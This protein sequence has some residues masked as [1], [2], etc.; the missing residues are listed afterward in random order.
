MKKIILYIALLISFINLQA[1]SQSDYNLAF[2]YYN[3]QDFEKA[4]VLFEKIFKQ[5]GSKSYFTYYMS[6]LLELKDFENAEKVVKKQLKK[7][8]NDNFYT[9][10]LGYV[11]KKQNFL[12]Q[13]EEQFSKAID[14]LSTEQYAA[15]ELANIFIQRRDYPLAEK[16]YLKAREKGASYSYYYELASV[17]SFDRN[18]EKMIN[19]YTNLLI[20]DETQIGNIQN[21]LQ[22]Y[23]SNDIDGSF[24]EILR[25]TTLKKL[26]QKPDE[27]ILNELLIWLFIQKNNFSAAF[28]QEVAIDKRFDLAGQRILNLGDLAFSNDDFEAANKSFNYIV[29]LH[30]KSFFYAQAKIK[31][32]KVK[33][34]ILTNNKQTLKTE[35]ENLEKEYLATLNDLGQTARTIPLMIELAHIQAFYLEKMQQGID[36]LDYASGLPDVKTDVQAQCFLEMADIYMLMGEVWEATLIYAKV[37]KDNEQNPIGHEAKFKKAQLAFYIGDFRWAEAQLDALKAATSKLIANDAFQLSQL[38]KDNLANDTVTDALKIFARA[39]LLEVQDKN[40]L[41]LI[42]LDTL[43]NQYTANSVIDEAWL[44]KADIM[45][46][47]K[48]YK[49]EALFLQKIVDDF[50]F[51]IL[52]D[53]ALFRLAQLNQ[54]FFKD[55]EKAMEFYKTII[56][57]FP[58]SIHVSESRKIYRELRG[59]NNI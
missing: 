29:S 18:F 42:T 57:D 30:P 26:Q 28:T 52:A 53:D 51:D 23:V 34:H 21:R 2:K 6:C 35:Y 27:T 43:L 1:Q 16:V 56:I 54:F 5:N 44:K 13:A 48:D 46:K 17:Y 33:Y 19:E 11:Y 59:D 58:A 24:A 37:E 55:L 38:I 12:A 8:P 20:D 45:H 41:A 36:L 32:L 40:N 39:G 31:L 7:Y 47:L 9:V 50:S 49:Q 14:N 22:Y 4:V 10:E 15:N 3:E 25:K